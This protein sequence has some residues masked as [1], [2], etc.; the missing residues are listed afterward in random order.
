[1]HGRAAMAVHVP[2]R[3]RQPGHG[4]TTSRLLGGR[5]D[6]LLT[7]PVPTPTW[8]GPSFAVNASAPAASTTR[9]VPPAPALPQSPN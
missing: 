7:H 4:P 9:G 8:H 1:M 6:P 2:R 3:N 5:K